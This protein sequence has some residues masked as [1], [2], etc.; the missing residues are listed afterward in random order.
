MDATPGWRAGPRWRSPGAW[1]GAA[2]LLKGPNW[3]ASTCVFQA[4]VALP[5][6]GKSPCFGYL[7][8][9]VEAIERELAEEFAEE[10]HRYQDE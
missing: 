4:N 3:F 5:G 6:D 8:T 10:K 7:R 1:R 9:P 2:S